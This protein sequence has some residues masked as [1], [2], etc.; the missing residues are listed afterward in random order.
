MNKVSI[1]LATAMLL[2]SCSSVPY[3]GPANPAIRVSS[4]ATDLSDT[5]KIKLIL[6]Q[7]YKEWSHVRHRMGGLS[8]N[9][10]DCSGLVYR[11]YRTKFGIDMPRSTDQQS[12]L[13]HEIRQSQ[14]RA[15]DLVFF[16]TG[17]FSRHVGMYID[18]D[19]F[20]HVSSS[21]GVM[22]SSLNNPYW[23]RTYWKAVRI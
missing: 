11:T 8:K 21:K 6:N 22:K 19:Q 9:G 15:G 3:H 14:L 12:E 5:Q 10:I 18:R 13:G 23:K 17:L 2:M 16:R 7:Q 4:T 20:L 1:V